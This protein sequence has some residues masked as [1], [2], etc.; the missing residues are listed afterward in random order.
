MLWNFQCRDLDS[1]EEA[2]VSQSP[3]LDEGGWCALA[4]ASFQFPPLPPPCCV[5]FGKLLSLSGLC[6]FHL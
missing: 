3:G 2:E 6:F 5:T 4:P 1:V